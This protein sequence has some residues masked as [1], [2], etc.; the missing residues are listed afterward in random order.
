MRRMR[1]EQQGRE[2]KRAKPTQTYDT[3]S[4]RNRRG[5]EAEKCGSNT[6]RLR[7]VGAHLG[8]ELQGHELS[9]F[10]DLKMWPETE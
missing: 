2:N 5:T 8:W 7:C 6:R 4:R 1:Y 9:I 10:P 3:A